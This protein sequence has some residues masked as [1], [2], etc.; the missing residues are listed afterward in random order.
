MSGGQFSPPAVGQS[1]HP[2]LVYEGDVRINAVVLRTEAQPVTVKSHLAPVGLQG[3]S[4]QL[5][6]GAFTGPVQTN[7][8]IALTSQHGQT[9][10][11][12]EFYFQD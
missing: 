10:G 1:A 5:E 11:E 7:Q 12:R 3:S 6:G 4:H 2:E 9:G 8:P